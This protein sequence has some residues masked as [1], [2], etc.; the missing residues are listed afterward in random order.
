ML[1]L[2]RLLDTADKLKS[3]LFIFI[4]LDTD[5]IL[6]QK[7]FCSGGLGCVCITFFTIS[8]KNA[9]SP[10]SPPIRGRG[11]GRQGGE[12]R[13]SAR[14]GGATFDPAGGDQIFLLGGG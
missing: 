6:S 5:P 8:S 2:V 12:Q 13:L 14:G 1:Q 7:Y 9:Q 10:P 4:F 3:V 11:V